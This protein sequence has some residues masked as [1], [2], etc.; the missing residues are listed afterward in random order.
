M[1][2]VHRELYDGEVVRSLE[3][4]TDRL[5]RC[6][7]LGHV[8][9][10]AKRGNDFKR[11]AERMPARSAGF[12]RQTSVLHHGSRAVDVWPG[13]LK[14]GQPYGSHPVLI[15][16]EFILKYACFLVLGDGAGMIRVTSRTPN[17]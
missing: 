5:S 6:G 13:F 4:D 7:L 10:L 17:R 8:E 12:H 11:K 15:P 16:G 14:R 2:K 9:E 1:V 3:P